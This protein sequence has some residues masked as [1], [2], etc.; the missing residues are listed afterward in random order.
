MRAGEMKAHIAGLGIAC[1]D[2]LFVAP[3]AESGGQGP[4]RDYAVEGGGLVGTALVAAAR[5]GARAEVWTWVGDDE[6]GELVIEGLRA[7]GVD[8]SGLEVVA[9]ERTPV[10]FIQVEEGSG[11]RTIYHRRG[12]EV[13][14]DRAR[15]VGRELSCDVLL[16]DAVWPEASQSAAEMARGRGI[17]VVGDFCPGEGLRGLAAMVDALIVPRGCAERL[18]PGGSWEERLRIVAELGPSFAAITAGEEGCYYLEGGEVGHQAA[19][20]VE[21]VDTTGAGDV[22]H[23]AFAYGLAQGWPSAKCVEFASAVAA[24]S[25]RVLGGRRGI[26]TVGEAL[27]YL[28]EHGSG[29]WAE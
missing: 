18:A 2:Y 24:L 23:G 7:E 17:P 6:E 13:R 20:E 22:F 29:D 14:G 4:L 21:V 10:S 25:C 12:V 15:L 26:P 8:T 11:E 19:F 3:R 28:G 16:V 9:G 27:R 5:L 1:L